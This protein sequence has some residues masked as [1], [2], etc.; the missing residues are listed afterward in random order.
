[1]TSIRIQTKRERP[2]VCGNRTTVYEEQPAAA[3]RKYLP[4]PLLYH[5]HMHIANLPTRRYLLVSAPHAHHISCEEEDDDSLA[6]LH[7][8]IYLFLGPRDLLPFLRCGCDFIQ[9]QPT[10]SNLRTSLSPRDE[11]LQSI[12]INVFKC[13]INTGA[14]RIWHALR[15]CE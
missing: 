10:V 6:H 13:E 14:R 12:P 4:L 9:Q 11:R 15:G 8:R 3:P 1:M 7:T 5:I 2:S